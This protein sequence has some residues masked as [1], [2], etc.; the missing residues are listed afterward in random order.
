MI[1]N[2]LKS[3]HENG[4]KICVFTNQ[5]GI[6]SG[7]T[8]AD[9]IK[10]KIFMIS[11]RLDVPCSFSLDFVNVNLTPNRFSYNRSIL[12]GNRIKYLPETKNRN[13]ESF[14]RTI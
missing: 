1:P 8:S 11:Q 10:R 3:L 13:V 12:C 14:G 2:K 7:K 9:E 4:F 6:E 5:A